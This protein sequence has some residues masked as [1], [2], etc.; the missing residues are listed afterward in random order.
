[1]GAV[2][3][4]LPTCRIS[5]NKNPGGGGLL[6][7]Q[8]PTSRGS[9]CFSAPLP[10]ATNG[11]RAII[12]DCAIIISRWQ[13]EIFSNIS[14]HQMLRNV[15]CTHHTMGTCRYTSACHAPC[16][17]YNMN[18]KFIPVPVRVDV[19]KKKHMPLLETGRLFFR[20]FHELCYY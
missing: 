3:L 16:T 15:R 1:M 2:G 12:R 18:A 19:I 17:L 6:L 20:T 5:S 14:A 8:C 10:R 4:L 13:F 7:F 9:Y 11:D